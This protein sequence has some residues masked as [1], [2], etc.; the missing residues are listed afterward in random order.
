MPYTWDDENNMICPK[1][2][3]SM[4]IKFE[5]DQEGEEKPHYSHDDE[6]VRSCGFSMPCRRYSDWFGADD[7]HREVAEYI[8]NNK[9]CEQ[10]LKIFYSGF[11]ACLVYSDDVVVFGYDGNEYCHS[12]HFTNEEPHIQS[13]MAQVLDLGIVS[14]P[15]KS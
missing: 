13:F 10:P 14:K 4:T 6:W 11:M 3:S 8:E 7:L 12:F 1:C 5:F 9:D 2:D 15:S